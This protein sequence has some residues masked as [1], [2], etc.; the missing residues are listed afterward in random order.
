MRIVITCKKKDHSHF[1]QRKLRDKNFD[2]SD[3][4]KLLIMIHQNPFAL[5]KSVLSH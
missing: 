4:F 2:F 5:Q 3:Q 1:T